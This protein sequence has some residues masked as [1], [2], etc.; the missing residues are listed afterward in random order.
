MGV[1]TYYTRLLA[2][3]EFPPRNA[4]LR[5][6]ISGSAP[7]LAETFEAFRLRTGA[8]ILER[9]GMTE[10]GM[11]TSNPLD[12][13]RRA[14]T[15]G[16]PL[17]GVEARV[18]AADGTLARVGDPGILEIRGDSVFAGYWRNDE[19]TRAAFSADGFFITGDVV[20]VDTDGVVSI[21]GRH[22][23]LIISGGLNVY[24][25]EVETEIDALPG[26]DESAV[27]GVPHPD[28]GEAVI[29]VVAARRPLLVEADVI[30]SLRTR[31]AAFM[32]PKRVFWVDELP[33]N[34]MGKVQKKALRDEYAGLFEATR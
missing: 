26:I 20:T 16:R 27:V 5:L 9:Y 33:R 22:N 8:T 15:V 34:A 3:P 2:M 4:V 11:I 19:K 25:K 21:V 17:P 12:G 23:D 30:G 32:V 6:W 10:A 18:R 1:P 14:G 28:F 29:A 7:L 13:S 31:L 24:P